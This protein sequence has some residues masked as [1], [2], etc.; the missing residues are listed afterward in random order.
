M[1]SIPDGSSEYDAHVLSVIGNA[2]CL[3]HLLKLKAAS[4]LFLLSK[5]EM[6]SAQRF[7]VTF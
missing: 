5:N 7:R 6:T 3:R 1:A 2:I 4:N